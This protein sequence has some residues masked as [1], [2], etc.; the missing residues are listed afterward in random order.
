MNFIDKEIKKFI[1][2]VEE[3]EEKLFIPNE[4]LVLKE[5]D[6][7]NKNIINLFKDE[8][9]DDILVINNLKYQMRIQEGREKN[10]VLSLINILDS[11]D[12]L[13]RNAL[14][15]SNEGMKKSIKTT[16]I[17]INRELENMKLIRTPEVG[18]LYNENYHVCLGYKKSEK[19]IDKQIIEVIKKGYI[20]RDKVI[21]Q[22]EVIVVNNSMEENDEYNRN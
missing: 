11:I 7:L 15:F 8:R 16:N 1:E 6:N 20:F 4:D 22:S 14:I 3:E 18:D 10:I 9:E 5:I 13:L 21:R 19:L 12:W 2:K 17:L